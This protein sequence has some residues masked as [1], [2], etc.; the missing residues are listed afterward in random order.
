MP[1]L[2]SINFSQ[3]TLILQWI[4]PTQKLLANGL[5]FHFFENV[6]V[7]EKAVLWIIR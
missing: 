2:K 7:G 6:G 1:Y 3:F 5:H 4:I